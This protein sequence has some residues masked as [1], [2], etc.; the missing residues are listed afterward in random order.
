[1]KGYRIWAPWWMRATAAVNLAAVILTLMF[2]TGKGTGSLGERMMYIHA[3][4]T[5]V[6]W[7]W[8]S[9]LLAVLALT[10]VFA[11]LTRVLDSGYRP[12]LQMALLI[13]IIGA[14]AWMLHDIIQMTFMPALSQ[15]FLEVPTERMAGYIIQWEALL[16]KLLGVFSCSCFAVSGYIYTAVMYR[17]DHFSNRVALYSLAVWSFVLLSSLAFRWS[18]NLLPWLTA[19][20]LLLTVPWSWFLAKE[21]IRNRKESPVATEKG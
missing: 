5:V 17:T 15:M 1:M 21:I 10:G 19:C 13:W 8:G 20:S 9:N 11:V 12:V 2:L 4:K 6:F 14:M 3:N 18:E 7:S 16:G